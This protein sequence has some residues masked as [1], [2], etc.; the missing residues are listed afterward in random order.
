MATKHQV[1]ELLAKGLTPQ[2]IAKKLGCSDAYVRATRQRSEHPDYNRRFYESR[3]KRCRE[4]YRTDAAYREAE[5]AAGRAYHHRKK[6]A[7][8]ANE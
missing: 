5:K 3:N 6:E 8:A 2:Q 7:R 1:L 4:R